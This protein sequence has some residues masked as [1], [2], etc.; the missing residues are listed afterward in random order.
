M[1]CDTSGDYAGFYTGMAGIPVV[2]VTATVPYTSLFQ[3]L[4]F[5]TTGIN[6]V[7][8]SEVPVMGI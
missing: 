3:T 8:N 7:A 6:I 1:R 4:G 2:T 5:D